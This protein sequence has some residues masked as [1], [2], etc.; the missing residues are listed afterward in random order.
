MPKQNQADLPS[1]TEEEVYVFTLLEHM[2][3][4]GKEAVAFTKSLFNMLS[5]PILDQIKSS[6]MQLESSLEAKMDA[7]N[8][9]L[10][11]KMDTQNSRL[12]AKMDTQNS[13]LEAKMDSLEAQ[14]GSLE[15]KM[16]SLEAQNGSLEAKMDSLETQNGSLKEKIDAQD[17]RLKSEMSHLRWFVG[18]LV[19]VLGGVLATVVALVAG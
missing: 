1:S 7:Q 4:S 5:T 11:A 17:S 8:N 18:I 3:C 16:D 6:H 13:R 15:A 10:E 9:S 2:G 14:N 19:A 12:E